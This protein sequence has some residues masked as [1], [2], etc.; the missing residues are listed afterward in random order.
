MSVLIIFGLCLLVLL[1]ASILIS[2]YGHNNEI[3]SFQL[4]GTIALCFSLVAAISYAVVWFDYVSSDSKAKI[5]NSEYG[6]KYTRED[7]FFASDVIDKIR[8]IQRTRIELNG[9]IMGGKK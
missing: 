7:V 9:N 6:T 8:E 3:I 5:I 1:V 2:V 4:I